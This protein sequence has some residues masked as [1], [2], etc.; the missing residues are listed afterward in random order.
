MAGCIDPLIVLHTMQMLW[1]G[2]MLYNSIPDAKG[3]DQFLW[4][5]AFFMPLL[6]SVWEQRPL[7]PK[8]HT[9]TPMSPMT[10]HENSGHLV[11]A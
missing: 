3:K 11:A 8:C 9:L 2:D 4:F 7:S 10:C 1:V 5:M 6:S